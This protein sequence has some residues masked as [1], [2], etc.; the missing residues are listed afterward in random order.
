[1]EFL[2]ARVRNLSDGIVFVAES[3]LQRASDSLESIDD[4]V[5]IELAAADFSVEV[6]LQ[7][8]AVEGCVARTLPADIRVVAFS[9]FD[10]LNRAQ[11]GIYAGVCH[12]NV[13]D[14]DVSYWLLLHIILVFHVLDG[15]G[16]CAV[17]VWLNL[18]S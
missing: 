2:E 10:V 6:S 14:N 5:A 15:H 1:M 13:L 7:L 11:D 16:A 8:A 3:E 18:N 12:R 9:D 17:A 4:E